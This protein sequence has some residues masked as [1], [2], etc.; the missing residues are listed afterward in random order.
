M[1]TP[2]ARAR[3]MK[4]DTK[5]PLWLATAIRPAGGYGATI[6]AHSRAGVDTTPLTVRSG[7]QDPEIVGE[8]HQLALGGATRVARLAVAG[9]RQERRPHPLGGAGAE[10]LG[11]GGGR[12]ADEHQVDGPVGEVGD[13]GHRSHAEDFLALQVGAEDA[14]RV[15]AGEQVVQRRR[16]R[17]C[18]GASTRR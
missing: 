17:T 1:P 8:R 5:F 3:F 9:R 4:L 13:V 16:S 6:W 11:V 12:R 18:R 2:V 10:D 14:A 15:P 7:E